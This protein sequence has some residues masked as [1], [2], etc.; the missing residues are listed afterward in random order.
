MAR[1]VFVRIP[2]HTPLWSAVMYHWP[3]SRSLASNTATSKPASSACFAAARPDGPAPMT[4]IR[5]PSRSLT[6]RH[7]LR[8]DRRDGVRYA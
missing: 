7:Y 1:L 3:P 6:A 4:A 8:Q 5:A 2:V